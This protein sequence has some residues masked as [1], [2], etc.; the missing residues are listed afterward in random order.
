ME[1]VIRIQENIPQTTK[2]L[3]SL[4]HEISHAIWWVYRLNDDDKE[5]RIV[6]V[7]GMAWTQVYRDNPWL[8]E[9]IAESMKP[10]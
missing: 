9:W 3:E 7:M 5:E 4:L 6:S 8:I 1:F 2:A 10:K